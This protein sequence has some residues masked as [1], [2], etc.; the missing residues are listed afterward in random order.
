MADGSEHSGD[1]SVLLCISEPVLGSLTNMDGFG[2][3]RGACTNP[4]HNCPCY[5]R[6]E[7]QL[8]L[9]CLNCQG[10]CSTFSH[11]S[12]TFAQACVGCAWFCS[13]SS[14]VDCQEPHPTLPHFDILTGLFV[15]VLVPFKLS[16]FFSYVSFIQVSHCFISLTAR[17]TPP[18]SSLVFQETQNNAFTEVIPKNIKTF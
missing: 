17:W 5:A 7:H 3:L 18:Q 15:R 9:A 11:V 1:S 14:C 16:C 2:K 6:F 8:S 12:F 13:P 10:L 4:L